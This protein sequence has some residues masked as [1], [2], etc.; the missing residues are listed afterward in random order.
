MDGVFV[1]ATDTGVGKTTVAAGLLKLL[2]GSR[3]VCYWKPIQTG[4]VIGDDTKDVIELTE[5][6]SDAFMD[7]G[8]RFADPVAPY[9]AARA[10][11]K[12]IDIERLV[13]L[14]NEAKTAGKFIITE[15]AGGVLVP[16]SKEVLLI[17]LIEKLKIPV[18]LVAP[19]TLGTIN[20]TLLTVNALREK[21]IEILG[22]ILTR[23]S[24]Q[25][26]RGNAECISH[27]GKVKILAEFREQSDRR[28]VISQVSCDPALR[29]MFNVPE[30]PM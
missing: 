29:K 25:S 20:Q 27:F 5:L 24:Q 7:P 26:G 18:L 11:K 8:Y 13:K 3:N 14:F 2:H 19:D 10:W 23:S 30:I 4:T 16:L 9:L 1:T 28:T 15:G 21:E 6:G 22:V 12:E 17:D